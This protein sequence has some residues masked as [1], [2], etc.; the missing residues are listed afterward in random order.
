[1]VEIEIDSSKCTGCGMCEEVCPRN[2]FKIS[3]REE[4][5]QGK[6]SKA[7]SEDGCL[8]CMAC[9]STCKEK[10]IEISDPSPEML[11]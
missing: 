5:G 2:I 6:V 7:E 1:M 9:V 11:L 3:E 8:L 10:C 4:T